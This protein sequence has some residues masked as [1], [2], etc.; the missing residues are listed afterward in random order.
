[1]H[2]FWHTLAEATKGANL[3]KEEAEAI[4][5]KFLQEKKLIDLSGWKLVEANSDKRPNRTDHTLTWQENAP[6]DLQNSG[7]KDPA[8]HAYARMSLKVL[9][10]EPADYRTYIKIPEGFETPAGRRNRGADIGGG[11]PDLRGLGLLIGVLVYFF[12][13]LRVQPK[14]TVPWKRMV[15]WGLVGLAGFLGS[16]FFG[17]GIP[18]LLEQYPTTMPLRLFFGTTA[19]GV[20]LISALLVG[21]ITLLF[22]LAWSFAARAFGEAQLP[23]WLGMPP[24]YYRDAF[25]IGIGGSAI[26]IGL[27]HLARF[28]VC[29]VANL[30]PWNSGELWRIVRRDLPRYRGNRRSYI[31]RPLNERRASA[32]RSVSGGGASGALAAAGSV[33]CGG[34]R[35]GHRLGLSCGFSEAISGDRRFF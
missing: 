11:R 5:D 24:D 26:L 12:K 21:A 10:D 15:S 29:L 18:A 34:G 32:G 6:L 35:A 3:S 13:R 25:W 8:D 20:F 9:G 17:R 4:A 2:G 28:C 16:F 14:V 7:A 22:G 1:M 27:R 23:T 31:S 30:A 19:V 33:L